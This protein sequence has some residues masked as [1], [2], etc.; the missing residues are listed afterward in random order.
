MRQQNPNADV[1]LVYTMQAQNEETVRAGLVHEA[2]ALHEQ[3]AQHYNLPSIYVGPAVVQAIDAGEAVFT[4]II[5]D[6]ASGKDAT[7]RPNAYRS[8][9]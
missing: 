9:V 6:P 4:G 8:L 1:C 3:V 2:A 5:A 7:G